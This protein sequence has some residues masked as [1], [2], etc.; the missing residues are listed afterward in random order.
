LDIS[1]IKE[2]RSSL[3]YEFIRTAYEPEVEWFH[4]ALNRGG[5]WDVDPKDIS[6]WQN[7]INGIRSKLYNLI[8]EVQGLFCVVS[9]SHRIKDRETMNKLYA[10]IFSRIVDI[11]LKLFDIQKFTT[12]VI[13]KHNG[14][15]EELNNLIPRIQFVA[16]V[17]LLTPKFMREV[18]EKSKNYGLSKEV[19]TVLDIAWKIGYDIS[20]PEIDIL[21]VINYMS[22]KGKKGPRADDWRKIVG[23]WMEMQNE[24][25]GSIE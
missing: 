13:N 18:V 23:S 1:K 6:N 9:W 20:A 7:S 4:A 2:I 15:E 10:V 17:S 8:S 19:E 16:S 24:E 12:A 25:E 22:I 21:R 3:K 5:Y 11:Q 14:L